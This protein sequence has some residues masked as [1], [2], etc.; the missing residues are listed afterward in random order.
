MS[1]GGKSLIRV[2]TRKKRRGETG[3]IKYRYIDYFGYQRKKRVMGGQTSVGNRRMEGEARS[4]L[5][6]FLKK[7]TQEM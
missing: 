3:D 1:S 5:A 2:G 4:R 6:W 7:K